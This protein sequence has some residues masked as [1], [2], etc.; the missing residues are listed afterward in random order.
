TK[1]IAEV[2]AKRNAKVSSWRHLLQT[3]SLPAERPES[4]NSGAA[5]PPQVS[6]FA[7]REVLPRRSRRWWRD[8]A[9]IRRRLKPA[10]FKAVS[11]DARLVESKGKRQPC[12]V[13]GAKL[14][15]VPICELLPLPCRTSPIELLVA[16]RLV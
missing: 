13:I 2:D 6:L 1:R 5:G 3:L 16:I 12:A 14:A 9:R 11:S 15:S 7:R 4:L 8:S 10:R